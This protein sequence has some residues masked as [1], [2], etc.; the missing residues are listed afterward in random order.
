[1]SGPSDISRMPFGSGL[2]LVNE[3]TDELT[4]PLCGG[5]VVCGFCTS[6]P[7]FSVAVA[8]RGLPRPPAMLAVGIIV[9]S[10]C[11]D[12]I[13]RVAAGSAVAAPVAVAGFLALPPKR[14][15]M[16]LSGQGEVDTA[17]E[18]G[19]EVDRAGRGREDCDSGHGQWSSRTRWPSD[20]V[21]SGRGLRAHGGAGVAVVVC[22]DVPGLGVWSLKAQWQGAKNA[23]H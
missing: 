14:K 13:L 7:S 19:Q 3:C 20:R 11:A 15:D 6:P 10:P 2:V 12:V 22:C 8:G 21:S 1:M 23:A 4:L 9:R 18:G 16:L 17:W 5:G